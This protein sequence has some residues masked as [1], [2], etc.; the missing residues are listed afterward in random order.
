MYPV[1]RGAEGYDLSVMLLE[2]PTQLGP[3]AFPIGVFTQS[4]YTIKKAHVKN[5]WS[6]SRRP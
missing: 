3:E 1:F 5:L 2:A 6:I 4:A